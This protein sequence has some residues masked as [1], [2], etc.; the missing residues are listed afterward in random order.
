NTT[1]FEAA[2]ASGI[3]L[4]HSCLTARCRS[5]VVKIKEGSTKD[6]TDDL[7]LTAQEKSAN[8]TLSC[9][10]YPTSDLSLDVEDL[11]GL[12]WYEKKIVP[13]KIQTIEYLTD[14]VIR[15]L[16]RMPPTANFKY[17]SGQY[18]N[19][20]KGD[21][22]RSYSVANAFQENS[23]LEFYI[24]KYEQGLMSHYW[25]TQAKENDLLRV[26]G[27]LGSFFLRESP[28][29]NIV[30]LA[31]GTGIAPVKAILEQVKANELL[32]ADKT[33]WLFFGARTQ[34]DIFWE[35]TSIPLKKL[36]FTKVLSR[37]TTIFTGFK[38]YVQNAVLEASID[39]SD[40]QVYACGSNDMI[41]A[42]KELFIKH[43][44]SENNFFSD[45]FVATN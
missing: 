5:C 14:D 8:F 25:F 34:Q 20:S 4:E 41:L 44:L 6:K 28:K 22:K 18:V 7:V 16:L 21:L 26:E 31:T 13:A 45:A 24:K 38:G 11:S 39:L 17:N 12:A 37:E 42:A 30:L 9:N 27:P 35:P 19:I 3:L 10:A 36:H 29:K 2:K 15:V 33:F 43:Q 1:I 23:S 32:Y 40:A